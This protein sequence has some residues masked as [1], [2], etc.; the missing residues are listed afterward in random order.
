MS[1]TAEELF[2]RLLEKDRR[3]A[4][5]LITMVENGQPE[6][7]EALR[8]LHRHSGRAHIVGL[9][10]SP[11]SGKST[12]TCRLAQHYRSLDRSVGIIC[13]D[14]TS[15]FT[16]GALLGDRVR[17]QELSGDPEV[18]IR[19]MGSR[20]AL[21]GLSVATNDVINI[22]DAFGKDYIIVETVGAGQVEIEIVKFA[23]T[24]I[25][26]TM[27]GAGDEI[28]AIKAGILEIGDI[29]VVNKADREGALRTLSDL[30]MMVE[31]RPVRE[32]PTWTPPVMSCIALEGTGVE[33]LAGAIDDHWVYLRQSGM[34]EQKIIG[35]MRA[36]MLEILNLKVTRAAGAVIDSEGRGQDIIKRMVGRELDPHSAADEMAGLLAERELDVR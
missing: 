11:G 31:T 26:V 10:G 4:A 8:L 17:M 25:V 33:E 2:R 13:V 3:A 1:D 22:L 32:E 34:L 23:Q 7:R 5:R 27:P 6:A 19:S 36:E 9:T 29:F 35:R 18:F 28:Q 21:G 16:G 12:L 30:E 14:P 24:C 15:P 20:G